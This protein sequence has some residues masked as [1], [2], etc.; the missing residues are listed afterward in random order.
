MYDFGAQTQ[1]VEPRYSK[2][3]ITE[4]FDQSQIL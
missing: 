1:K 4:A 3:P 2:W